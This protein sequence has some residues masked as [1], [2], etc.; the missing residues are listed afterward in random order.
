[1]GVW[2]P[3]QETAFTG[4]EPGTSEHIYSLPVSGRQR[5]G[6]LDRGCGKWAECI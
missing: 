4:M 1:M 2:T 6:G 3:L 5:A